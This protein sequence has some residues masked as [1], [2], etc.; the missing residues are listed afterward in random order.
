MMLRYVLFAGEN[1]YPDGG[2][3]DCIGCFNTI[4][5]AIEALSGRVDWMNI[6]DSRTGKIFDTE[7]DRDLNQAWHAGSSSLLAWANEMDEE[8]MADI[9]PGT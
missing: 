8:A 9:A 2:M 1:Y 5:E 4:R 3:Q 6:L 7:V